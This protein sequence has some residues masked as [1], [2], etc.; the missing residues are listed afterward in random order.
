MNELTK[1]INGNS[2]SNDNSLIAS[3]SVFLKVTSKKYNSET[4]HRPKL[5]INI[6][7]SDKGRITKDNRYGRT[8]CEQNIKI[9][10]AV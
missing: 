6:P 9:R 8:Y 7:E 10:A 1:I 3:L 2:I 5:P 4:S